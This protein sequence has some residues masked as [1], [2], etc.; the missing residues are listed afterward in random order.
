MD[1]PGLAPFTRRFIRWAT[2]SYGERLHPHLQM[3][4]ETRFW[5]LRNF[6]HARPFGTSSDEFNLDPV[7]DTRSFSPSLDTAL[8]RILDRGHDEARAASH[9]DPLASAWNSNKRTCA[10]TRCGP[11]SLSTS[12][13]SCGDSGALANDNHFLKQREVAGR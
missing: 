1:P 9:H 13:K 8:G 11:T 2:P 5:L 7:A 4:V 12:W 6:V 10:V 3:K